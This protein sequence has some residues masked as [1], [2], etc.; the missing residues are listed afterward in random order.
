VTGWPSPPFRITYL[1]GVPKETVA[2]PASVAAGAGAEEESA[3][4]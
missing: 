2:P 1:I 4:A 3:D